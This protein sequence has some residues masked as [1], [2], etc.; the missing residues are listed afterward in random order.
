MDAHVPTLPA[1][2]PHIVFF[3]VDDL[4]WG[5]WPRAGNQAARSL[6]PTIA[7]VFVDE[8]LDVT[9]HAINHADAAHIV[10][11]TRQDGTMVCALNSQH[12]HCGIGR[13]G[14]PGYL[15]SKSAASLFARSSLLRWLARPFQ[16]HVPPAP[17]SER[18]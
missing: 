15:A 12:A 1:S 16:K 10:H 8:G 7:Q 5:L 6:L 11:D 18:S 13:S 4:A 14:V 2:R 3:L 17:L 9:Q